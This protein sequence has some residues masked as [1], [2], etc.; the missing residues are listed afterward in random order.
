M[1]TFPSYISQQSLPSCL[2]H[3]PARPA[4]PA[5]LA[6]GWPR[7]ALLKLL[8]GL[9]CREKE[10]AA[11]EEE[12]AKERAEREMQ[13]SAP[14][15]STAWHPVQLMFLPFSAVADLPAL[16]PAFPVFC[17][18]QMSME[19]VQPGLSSLGMLTLCAAESRPQSACRPGTWGPAPALVTCPAARPGCYSPA[20]LPAWVLLT[21]P[22][23]PGC[24]AAGGGA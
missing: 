14:R 15:S 5:H 2:H 11:K 13:A 21:C 10:R 18:C 8:S 4:R 17:C 12:R 20:L 23:A 3:G 24:P 22:A 1:D 16:P 19:P 6:A 7:L 9:L